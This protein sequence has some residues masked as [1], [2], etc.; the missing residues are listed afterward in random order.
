MVTLA[1]FMLLA[2]PDPRPGLR[3]SP[4]T[5][6]APLRIMLTAELRGGEETEKFYC[7]RVEWEWPDGTRSAEES[8]CP[9]FERRDD[10][11]RSWR[12]E[13][14]SEAGALTFTVRF[15]K[16]DRLLSKV[17]ETVSVLEGRAVTDE[18]RRGRG[19]RPFAS[20]RAVSRLLRPSLRAAGLRRR[21]AAGVRDLALRHGSETVY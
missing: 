11:P 6:F 10:Y 5:G 13:I 16:G 17:S 19:P 12:R 21:A 20:P 4:K 18:E 7:P 9:E 8:D 2:A 14:L 1:L 3:V 15:Y